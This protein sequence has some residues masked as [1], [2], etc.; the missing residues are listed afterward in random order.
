MATSDINQSEW[1]SFITILED[2]ILEREVEFIKTHWNDTAVNTNIPIYKS[3]SNLFNICYKYYQELTEETLTVQQFINRFVDSDK[4]IYNFG[5]CD[6]FTNS[7]LQSTGCQKY[8][9]LIITFL[10]FYLRDIVYKIALKHNI[11]QLIQHPESIRFCL[12]HCKTGKPYDPEISEYIALVY[13]FSYLNKVYDCKI[14]S[15]FLYLNQYKFEDLSIQ[16]LQYMTQVKIMAEACVSFV[17]KYLKPIF[18]N[19]ISYPEEGLPYIP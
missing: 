19:N 5:H 2:Y 3:A 6:I 13:N 12:G 15:E 10:N 17:D 11:T 1:N 14:K 18:D 9:E 4:I 16:D 7:L 8:I